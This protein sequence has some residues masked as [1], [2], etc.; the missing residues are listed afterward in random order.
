MS[1]LVTGAAG[2]LGNNVV[3]QL[4]ARGRRVRVLVHSESA[5]LD[6]LPVEKQP[7]DILDRAS[8][9]RAFEGVE[10]VYHFAAKVTILPSEGASATRTNTLG[11]TNVVDA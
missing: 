9:D 11:P 6:G 4:L 1:V 7:G 3:R 2:H 10:V 8:L 5:S